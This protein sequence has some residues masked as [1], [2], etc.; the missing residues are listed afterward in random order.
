MKVTPVRRMRVTRACPR[1]CLRTVKRARQILGAPAHQPERIGTALCAP[2]RARNQLSL[3][4]LI[5]WHR[6]QH[7]ENCRCIPK[8]QPIADNTL[9][10]LRH[11]LQPE[12]D[13][14]SGTSIGGPMTVPHS[15]PSPPV[16]G[17]RRSGM[18]NAELGR[19][20]ARQDDRHLL[21][22]HHPRPRVADTSTPPEKQR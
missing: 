4:Y 9:A 14:H 15:Q 12:G 3:Q 13:P 16:D 17:A 18:P 2:R 10:E 5:A 19:R 7:G 1:L 11:D 8:A 22:R 20:L 6:D 21:C